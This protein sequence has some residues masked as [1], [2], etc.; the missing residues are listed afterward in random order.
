M[1]P[2]SPGRM[3]RKIETKY[4]LETVMIIYC[5]INR[6]SSDDYSH[7]AEEKRVCACFY[8]SASYSEIWEEFGITLVVKGQLKKL[9]GE[10]MFVNIDTT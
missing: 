5:S 10:F 3:I 4:F 1:T 2:L 8:P 6:Y 7:Y 9:F